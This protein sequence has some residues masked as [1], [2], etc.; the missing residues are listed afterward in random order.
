MTYFHQIPRLARR[1]ASAA[2]IGAIGCAPLP[3]AASEVLLTV[4]GA[5]APGGPQTFDREALA[6]LPRTDITTSTV[7]TAGVGRFTGVRLGDLMDAVGAKGDRLHVTALNDYAIDIPLADAAPDAAIIAYEL[8][9]KPM[10]VREKGPL[11]IVYPYD[12]DVKFRTETIYGRSV[13]Q[14]VR[15]EVRD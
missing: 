5:I 3:A 10:S 7:W 8:D 11:W 15:I 13:W 2:V 1:C 12:S 9:G 14:L 4:T 6:D